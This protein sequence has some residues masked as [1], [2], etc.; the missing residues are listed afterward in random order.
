MLDF[1]F[2]DELE[3]GEFIEW[4]MNGTHYR[5][6]VDLE[7][8]SKGKAVIDDYAKFPVPALALTNGYSMGIP[9]TIARL[10]DNPV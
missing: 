10:K 2:D 4:K 3:D 5:Y 9:L 6:E 7:Y 1:M 8:L